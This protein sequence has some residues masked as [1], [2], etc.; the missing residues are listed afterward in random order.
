MSWRLSCVPRA[1]DAPKKSSIAFVLA[2]R[3]ELRV[4]GEWVNATGGVGSCTSIACASRSRSWVL[5]QG[6]MEGMT[7]VVEVDAVEDMSGKSR[8]LLGEVVGR[9]GTSFERL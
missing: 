9:K 4:R 7:K 1:E 2:S 5:L 6:K 8:M 3:S